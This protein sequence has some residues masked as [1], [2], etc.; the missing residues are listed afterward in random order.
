MSTLPRSTSKGTMN[1]ASIPGLPMF[2][3]RPVSDFDVGINSSAAWTGS[4]E[5]AVGDPSLS[6]DEGE[7][8]EEER[9]RSARALYK[10]EG[11][12]EFRELNV[13]AGD[14]IEVLK[15][16]VGDGWSLVKVEKNGEVGLLPQSYYTFTSDF[17]AAPDLNLPARKREASAQSITPRGSPKLEPEQLP[18]L[19]QHTGE[20]FPSFRHS[21]L[22]GKALNRFSSFV[23]SGAEE[24]VLKG[25][26]TEPEVVPHS[27]EATFSD[28]EEGLSNRLSR[29]T[30]GEADRHFVDVGPSWKT[31]VPPFRVLVHSPSK[32]AST[33]SGAYTIYN[34]TSL[35]H[36][37]GTDD[38]PPPGSHVRVTVQRRFSHFVVLHTA[39]SRRLP[40][41]ALPPLP[42]KQYAGRFST[43][44]VEARRGDLERYLGRIV[45]HPVARYAEVLTFFLG[46]ESETEW[47]KQVPYHLALP[48]AGPSFYAHVFHPA[49]NLDAEDAAEAVERF[50][51]HTKAIGKGVQSLRN[52]FGQVRESR[53]EM[54]KAER[55]LSYS[56]L[57]LITSKPLASAPTT[58]ISEQ[59]DEYT[60]RTNGLM[61]QEGAWCW[62]EGCTDCLRLTKAIQRTSETL[63]SVADLYDVYARR[64]QLATHESM[65]TVAH[66]SSLYGGVVET[67]R[68]T[69]SRFKIAAAEQ[70]ADEEM[71]ARCETVLN[72][73]MA[74]MDTYH[75]QK[76]EDFRSLATDHL[77]G[78]I[79]FYEQILSRLES[80]RRAFD[81]PQYNDLA[82]SPRQPS[83]YERDLE[84]PRLTPKALPQPCPHVFD[85]APMRPV[86]VAI[87]EG[88]GMLF[89]GTSPVRSS[90]F[91][92]FW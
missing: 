26:P 77:D 65:K 20:W 80:A 69:L 15:E 78:E 83:I 9:G 61:N 75:T 10:F 72:T 58:G 19:P 39:L 64:T 54:S 67:H 87:Q 23:T 38:D 36:A 45:R 14:E 51:N 1:P 57:S 11:K 29:V 70:C 40:G 42:E 28:E 44:F 41:L 48:P 73:T 47:K 22:G 16:E 24:W 3:A 6:D 21:L 84:H 33:L 89:G 37:T 8:D 35:F 85:S 62:R 27:R 59:D 13:E 30:F 50:D 82:R 31:K 86:S 76:L 63:Q 92:K 90:V 2:H 56:L 25:S 5:R 81:S 34:V 7:D 74:E 79:A 71:V 91:G 55:L 66:P 60:G 17:M 68:S 49:F 52:I 32:R 88:V 53:I 43:E 46:C 4:L 12:V 18:L